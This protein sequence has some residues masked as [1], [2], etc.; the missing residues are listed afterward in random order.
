MPRPAFEKDLNINT[1]SAYV[2]AQETV[3]GWEELGS[4][5]GNK[6]FVYT[7]NLLNQNILPVS[8]FVTLGV[9]KSASAHWIGLADEVF[10]ED[11]EKG[12]RYV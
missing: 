7:G 2:A 1:V 6:T 4:K 11:K 3:C 9:G 5:G 8:A 10:K 12:W